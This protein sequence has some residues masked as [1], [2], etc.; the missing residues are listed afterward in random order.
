MPVYYR[1]MCRDPLVSVVS[2]DPRGRGA[3]VRV[4]LEDE[5]VFISQATQRARPCR[6]RAVRVAKIDAYPRDARL[7]LVII[8][9]SYQIII[10]SFETVVL[11]HNHHTDA[12]WVLRGGEEVL[13]RLLERADLALRAR[14]VQRALEA[15]VGAVACEVELRVREV[16]VQAAALRAQGAARQASPCPSNL[17]AFRF[18]TTVVSSTSI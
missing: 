18:E 1:H 17:S 8:E 16:E 11:L 14:L 5:V 15:E 4:D 6:T 3:R 9:P 12:L 13:Q 10:S 7:R 2:W